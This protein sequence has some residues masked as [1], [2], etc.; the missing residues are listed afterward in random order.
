MLAIQ[1][2]TVIL[3]VFQLFDKYSKVVNEESSGL[4]WADWRDIVMARKRPRRMLVQANTIIK[5]M[6]HSGDLKFGRVRISN[7]QSLSGF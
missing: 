3:N 2:P 4:L 7:G 5:G 1:V 6:G